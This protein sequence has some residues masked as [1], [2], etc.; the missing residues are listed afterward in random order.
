ML[1][2]MQVMDFS[3]AQLA[4][5]AAEY[6]ETMISLIPNF[7]DLTP[8]SQMN[9]RMRYVKDAKAAQ[10]GCEV[11]FW[12]SATRIKA[13]HSN[14][15]PAQSNTFDELLR[16]L[17]SAST[18]LESFNETVRTL[19]STFPEALG[20]LSWWL[21]PA[22]AATIF[23]A[24]KQMDPSVSKDIPSTSNPIEHSHSLLHH[25]TGKDHDLI[26]GLH[27]VFLHVQEIQKQYDAIKGK[28]SPS[29]TS[30]EVFI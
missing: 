22:I 12:R 1:T 13:S 9:E 25:A 26:V 29:T 11:H 18:S 5:H 4:A 6:A 30:Y 2:I 7:K 14:V 27:K 8:E 10:Q 23:P 17:L 24:R 15:P 16:I 28:L 20:W 21:R 3:A 19:Q